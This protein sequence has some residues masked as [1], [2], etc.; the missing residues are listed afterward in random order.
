MQS[1]GLSRVF[2]NTTVQ[3]HKEERVLKFGFLRKHNIFPKKG[4]GKKERKTTC[5]DLFRTNLVLL[6]L[7]VSQSPDALSGVR[8]AFLLVWGY[9]ERASPLVAGTVKQACGFCG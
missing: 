1:K 6:Q 5:L 4:T 7:K 8:S 9:R 3:K 2:S